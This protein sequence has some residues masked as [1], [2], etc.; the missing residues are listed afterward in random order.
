M[1]SALPRF[2]ATD[3]E[4]LEALAEHASLAVNDDGVVRR[5][6]RALDGATFEAQRD[7]LTGLLNRG[8]AI[9]ALEDLLVHVSEDHPVHA[10]FIDIDN[11]KLVN[12]VFGHSF[13]DRVLIAVAERL[14]NAVRGDDMVARLSG[15]EFVV[16]ASD[17]AGRDTARWA[18]RLTARIAE[19]MLIDGR[20]VRLSASVGIATTTEVLSGE[21]LIVDADVALYR[22]KQRGRG[23]VVH[24]DRRMRQE[25]FRRTELE[26]QL[27]TAV[28]DSEFVVHYQPMV[29]LDG[30][31]VCG[32]EALVRWQHPE[33]GLLAPPEFLDVAE[34]TGVIS[35]IDRFVL[36]ETCRKLAEW[37]EINPELTASVNLSARQFAD[38]QLFELVQDALT[39]YGL[40]GDRL[41]LEITETVVMDDTDVTMAVLDSVKQLGVRF[42][43]DDFGTGYSSL[44]YLKRFP[45]DVLKIDRSFVRGLGS[46]RD[47]EAIVRAILRLAEALEHDVVVEG[48]ETAE[49]LD[50]VRRLGCRLGQG[51][52]FSRPVPAETFDKM[53]SPPSI[54]PIV[55][56]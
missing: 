55:S 10:M 32:L 45:V 36:F 53:L 6:R 11:F 21:A 26:H 2:T 7:P 43:V 15:D 9:A 8:S 1:A 3:C 18:E 46:S 28:A 19:P 20:E 48:V 12:D 50:F 41:W 42:V 4:I 25:M 23:R 33:R 29:E 56:I 5:L 22:T 16:V 54:L 14:R 35:E 30:A 44:V 49:Q 27:R 37:S 34:E 40:E 17:M 52:Y 31:A 39:T 47:D 51:Y 38:R 13:G 24:F